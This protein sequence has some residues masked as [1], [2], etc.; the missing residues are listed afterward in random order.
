MKARVA[1]A[2]AV[3]LILA[4]VIPL[5]ARATSTSTITIVMAGPAVSVDITVEPAG[6]QISGVSLNSSYAR[7]FTLTNTGTVDVETSIAGTDA[8]GSGYEWKLDTSPG[9]NQYEIQ[10][11]IDG[12]S[13]DGN[14]TLAPDAFIDRLREG[15]ARDFS[16]TVRTPTGGGVPVAGEAVEATVTIRAVER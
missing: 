16:L 2:T 10:Y 1:F 3:A 8:V 14:V 4:T 11:E 13:G 15:A 6:W 7:D 12:P 9:Q 5:I